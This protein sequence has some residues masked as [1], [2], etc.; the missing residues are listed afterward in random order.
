MNLDTAPEKQLSLPGFGG[1]IQ[2]GFQEKDALVKDT[3][4]L[5]QVVDRYNL[6]YALQKVQSL[7][8]APV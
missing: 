4:L 8:A 7:K 6:F 2:V 5:E 3:Q 1:E